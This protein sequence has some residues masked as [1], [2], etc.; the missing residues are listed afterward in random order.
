MHKKEHE[1]S[2]ELYRRRFI[3]QATITLRARRTS[4]NSLINLLEFKYSKTIEF[5]VTILNI[6]FYK[7][8]AQLNSINLKVIATLLQR[9]CK[10]S[11]S[12]CSLFLFTCILYVKHKYILKKQ[13]RKVY[14]NTL[15]FLFTSILIYMRYLRYN[16]GTNT[17]RTYI[18]KSQKKIPFVLH[19]W[20]DYTFLAH[21]QT[22]PPTV[23][24]HIYICT[25]RI[26]ILPACS[27]SYLLFNSV[28]IQTLAREYT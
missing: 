18:E 26:M 17:C 13:Y 24:Y 10:T 20:D 16:W 19:M 6:L 22:P 4:S 5:F 7:Y 1:S 8:G 27:H 2:T 11:F 3:H 12:K 21:N 25:H 23:H 9:C 28:P 14:T 15:T